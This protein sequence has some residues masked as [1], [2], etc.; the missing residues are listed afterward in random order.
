MADPASQYP[1]STVDVSAAGPV[2]AKHR[3]VPMRSHPALTEKWLQQRI[4]EDTTLLGL[5]DVEVKD[6]ERML[7]RAGRLDL[8]LY[9]ADAN[10]RYAVELQ[11]GPTDESHIIRTIEYWDIER[12]RYPQYDHVGVIVAEEI[13]ARFF[14]VIALFNGFIPLIAVQVSAIELAGN[15][16]LVFTKVLD[17]IPIAVEEVEECQEPRDRAYWE[18]KGTKATLATTD[19]LLALVR[20]VEPAAA[21]NYNKHYI[22]LAV[23]GVASNWLV[24]RPRKQLVRVDVKI[25]RDEEITTRMEDAG[26]SVLS[27]QVRGGYYRLQVTAEDSMRTLT[28]SANSC[29]GP[30]APTAAH[31]DGQVR[32]AAGSVERPPH[33]GRN[34]DV[35]RDRPHR[36]WRTSALCAEAQS[37][38][39][40]PRSDP[41]PCRGVA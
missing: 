22:V 41:H 15:T 16:T 7:P 21:L 33:R 31:A 27:Y 35:R 23:N 8:L 26:L 11:L 12:R 24:M 1:A 18:G 34:A 17:T 14:N 29:G 13:T 3:V 37:L 38:V 6:V 10:T 9:D 40:E 30:R 2:Y 32:F 28:C 39:G 4:V 25:S 36:S 19:R 5:G 20:E